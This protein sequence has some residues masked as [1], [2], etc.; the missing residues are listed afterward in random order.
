MLKKSELTE[1]MQLL[2]AMKARLQGD[3]E[4]LT[5][6]ALDRGSGA[7]DSKSPTHIAELGTDNFEQDFALRFVENEQETLT[8]IDA[9]LKRIQDGT[10]G[11]CEMCLEEGKPKSKALIRKTR[12]RAIPFARNCVD[13]ERK[14][15]ELTR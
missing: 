13:C 11:L 14:R 8:E 5:A 12:L 4:H 9:A 6:G 3:V 15:E 7:T 1:F 10:Y 2:L